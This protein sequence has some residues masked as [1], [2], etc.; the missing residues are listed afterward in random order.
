[1]DIPEEVID[2][3]LNGVPIDK[4]GCEAIGMAW[5]PQKGWRKRFL[6]K[7]GLNTA[8]EERARSG[9]A[10]DAKKKHRKDRELLI[11]SRKRKPPRVNYAQKRAS[12]KAFYASWEWKKV[13]F[14]VLKKYGPVCMLCNAKENIV[15]DHIKP[16][17]KFPDLQLDPDNCQVLCNDCNMGKSN[18]DFTDFRP[19]AQHGELELV[20]DAARALE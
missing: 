3:I 19:E 11:G 18:D 15:V 4:A 13:R 5:P 14:E 20:W 7:Y 12:D 9:Q 17:S 10:R 2:K 16:R 8:A 1:M 6:T